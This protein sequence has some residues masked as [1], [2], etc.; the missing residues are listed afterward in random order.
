M[1]TSI[2]FPKALLHSDVDASSGIFRRQDI[3]AILRV[4]ATFMLIH[5]VCLNWTVTECLSCIYMYV[6]ILLIVCANLLNV[7][8]SC[9]VN[10]CHGN[11]WEKKAR[12]KF[13][14]A[15]IHAFILQI[16]CFSHY[17]TD[18]WIEFET[19]ARLLLL[20]SLLLNGLSINNQLEISLLFIAEHLYFFCASLCWFD[21]LFDPAVL[22]WTLSLAIHPSHLCYNKY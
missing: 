18:R 3:T 2:R 11:R 9:D 5:D 21:V 22:R 12:Y 8:K 16:F 13:S 14:W 19:V 6:R 7:E 20:I 10:S 15:K 4:A 1:L 17:C